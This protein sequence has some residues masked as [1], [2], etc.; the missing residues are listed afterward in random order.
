MYIARVQVLWSDKTPK[1][2]MLCDVCVCVE[3]GSMV[4]RSNLRWERW[5]SCHHLSG[6]VLWIHWNRVLAIL[7]K[8]LLIRQRMLMYWCSVLII[9]DGLCTFKFPCLNSRSLRHISE[10]AISR[11]MG[12]YIFSQLRMMTNTHFV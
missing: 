1:E 9:S 2:I 11:Q 10:G 3:V 5:H 6:L 12:P 8:I 7:E 4:W